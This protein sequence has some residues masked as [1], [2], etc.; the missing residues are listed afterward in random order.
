MRVFL[1]NIVTIALEQGVV[2]GLHQVTKLPKTKRTNPD[3][4]AATILTSVWKSLDNIVDF[5]EED[6]DDAVRRS[7]PMGFSVAG[8]STTTLTAPPDEE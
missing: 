7:A 5:K 2:S 6:E 8:V 3:I 1:K 4:V